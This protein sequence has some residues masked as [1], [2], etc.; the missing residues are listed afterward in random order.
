MT[1]IHPAP[2]P[3]FHHP[4]FPGSLDSISL[5]TSWGLFEAWLKW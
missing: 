2:F 3:V 4:I 5:Q 1:K